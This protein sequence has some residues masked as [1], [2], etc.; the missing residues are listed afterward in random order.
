MRRGS[1]LVATLV[2]IAM[3]SLAA[4]ACGGSDSGGALE[5][6]ASTL[7]ASLS[8]SPTAT[9][10]AVTANDDL[11]FAPDEITVS[12]GTPV[13][14]TVVGTISHTVTAQSGA[15]F[16]SGTLDQGETFTQTFTGP[17][18]IKY[19]CSIHGSSMSGTITVTQ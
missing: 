9:A 13:T 10:I 16:D 11:K 5:S 7:S 17:G 2:A 4:V 3:L 12:I 14:W 6:P 15:T 1:T 8:A 18:T 19:M